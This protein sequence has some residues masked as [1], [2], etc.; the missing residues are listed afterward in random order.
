LAVA[1]KPAAP[2][3]SKPQ[4][5]K[6]VIKPDF[7]T[8]AYGTASLIEA[9]LD[10]PAAAP[11]KRGAAAPPVAGSTVNAIRIK[12]FWR[13]STSSNVVSDLLKNLREKSTTFRFKVK[14]AKG[15]EVILVDEKIMDITAIGKPG[16]LGAPFEITLPL[17]REVSIK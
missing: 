13:T 1:A 4:N 15:A 6:S 11:G 12:G 9:K 8:A 2:N 7:A 3:A 16:E 14:D 17:A 5:G 10:Q